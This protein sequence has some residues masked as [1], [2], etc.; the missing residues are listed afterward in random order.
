MM[1]R[2]LTVQKIYPTNIITVPTSWRKFI[3]TLTLHLP[4]DKI[5]ARMKIRDI[6]QSPDQ[7]VRNSMLV[8]HRK[9]VAQAGL[10]SVPLVITWDYS[11]LLGMEF[12]FLAYLF[13]SLQQEVHIIN[14]SWSMEFDLH[15]NLLS[16]IKTKHSTVVTVPVILSHLLSLETGRSVDHK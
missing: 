5:A 9:P 11:L 7:R 10:P 6:T 13:S 16:L 4:P 14:E 2:S 12:I 15:L 3:C 8:P 1:W